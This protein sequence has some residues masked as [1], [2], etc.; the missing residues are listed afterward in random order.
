MSELTPQVRR[1]HVQSRRCVHTCA[2]PHRGPKADQLQPH[3]PPPWP[4]ATFLSLLGCCSPT[5]R[6]SASLPRSLQAAPRVTPAPVNQLSLLL[7]PSDFRSACPSRPALQGLS[8]SPTTQAS[9]ESATTQC[10][11]APAFPSSGPALPA[12]PS[13]RTRPKCCLP[14]PLYLP[15][16]QALCLP[17]HLVSL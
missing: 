9:P 11:V 4:L 2:W 6:L 8:P 7:N 15:R 16:E 14:S 3:C 12:P 13:L 10:L 17:I 5:T 1:G